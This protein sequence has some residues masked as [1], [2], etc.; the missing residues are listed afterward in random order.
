MKM[1]TKILIINNNTNTISAG[2]DNDDDD[3]DDDDDSDKNIYIYI[4]CVL[5]K[6]SPFCTCKLEG[7]FMNILFV[8][9]FDINIRQIVEYPRGVVMK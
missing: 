8:Y 3:V 9:I 1:I 6:I 7:I 4:F 2:S 5:D